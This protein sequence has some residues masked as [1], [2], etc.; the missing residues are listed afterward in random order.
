MSEILQDVRFAIRMLRR[1][2]GV[3]LLAIGSLAVA[4][5]GNTAVF[6]LITALL[7]Q[8][9]SVEDPERLVLLQERTVEQPPI[10]ST[11]STSLAL[12]ADMAQRSRTT[13]GW[14]ALR[15]TV[16]G[17]RGEDRSEPIT[18][19]EVT[20]SF[21]DVLGVSVQRGR[22]F[23]P[24]EGVPGAR[25]V[26]IVTP[27]FW[28]K[29]RGGV[30][31][32][33][34]EILTLDGGQVEVVGVMPE[35]FTFL[36]ANASVYVPL[37]D[38]PV[39]SPRDRR[40]VL[41]IARLAEGASMAQVKAE[42][43]S[44]AASLED[45]YPEV[46]RDWTV[47]VFNARIDIPDAR[48]K[49]FYG[50]LQGSVFF[51]LLIACVN[52]TNLLLARAQERRRE[53]AL[54]TALGAGR[55]R[56]TRQL[57]TES[58]VLVVTGAV[59][60]LGFG[61]AGI[62][63]LAN[64]FAGLLPA[65]Y[66]PELDGT[67]VLFTAG[68]SVFAG[69]FFG[70]A[71]VS[72]TL[73][74][75]QSEAL[76]EGGGKSSVGRSRNLITRTLVVSEIALSLI[77]LGGGGMLIRSFLELQNADPGFDGSSLVTTQIRVPDS[78]YPTDEER[79]LFLDALLER[80]MTVEGVRTAA[81]INSL[82]RNFQVP[83]DTFTVAGQI[84]D[85]AAAAPRA[86][87][88]KASP[89]YATAFGIEVLQGRFFEEGDRPGQPLVAVLNRSFADRWFPAG[90]AVGQFVEFEGAS[91]QVVGVVGDVQQVLV[92]T[93]GQVQSEAILL[94]AAQSPTGA[95]TL[96]AAAA[97]SPS[98]LKEP[99]RASLQLADPDLT[100]SP[101]LTM[102]EVMEQLFVGIS[103]FNAILGGFGLLAILLA[104]LGTYGVLAYQV[105]QRKREI[106]IRMAIG[107]RGGEVVSMVTRQGIW[108]AVIGL[109]LG[110]LF[111]VPLTSLLGTLL[112]GFSSVRPETG[113]YVAVVLFLVTLA[114][115]LIPAYRASALDPMKVLRDE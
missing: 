107:A 52:I 73:K 56:L 38:S 33:L 97:G 43:T 42:A 105:S 19:A 13:E 40:D 31:D 67:V 53:I 17:L 26:A 65:S 113:L 95:F 110:G 7:F 46:Q 35:G 112:A 94:P 63:A 3:T 45:Q 9:L 32:P 37:T 10:L 20:T 11:L 1:G 24:E 108:M 79:S 69:L 5:G 92:A 8:P 82:P 70:L 18:S 83:T 115:S 2:W 4:I 50:L 12:H 74:R 64:K 6:G 80:A 62:R 41:S 93:P 60:G 81:L 91:R 57:I 66:T 98:D 55:G 44:I 58:G 39:E 34:G 89:D 103:V 15:P 30:G 72:Q 23:L 100:L 99:I 28:E 71:P 22:T 88:L 111:L 36:F 114:A 29:N 78:K 87:S 84:R 16:L 25:R 102:D 14:A 104:S 47:D 51:V 27:E 77:A 109:A 76:K 86:F 59:L 85:V 48:T 106:G 75:G 96:V 21:F 68:V 101:M 90:N 61:W 54:R 49:V